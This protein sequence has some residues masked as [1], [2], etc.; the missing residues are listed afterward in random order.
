MEICELELAAPRSGEVEV[1]VEIA[2]AGV[3]GSDLHVV[4]GEWDVP[5]PV[6]LGPEG[7]RVVSA[8]G[9]DVTALA[10]GDHVILSWVPQ[11]GR[12]RQCR[13]ERPWQCER[14]ATVVA[15]GGV[16]SDHHMLPRQAGDRNVGVVT[17]WEYCR[18]VTTPDVRWRPDPAEK[19]RRHPFVTPQCAVRHEAGRGI[20]HR[21][22]H[23]P[24]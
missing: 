14:V 23:R 1:E 13:E 7:A 18:R 3:C 17:P 22:V 16:V 5:M 10:V 11:C 6:V 12:C 4:R 19:G 2:A 15:P 24:H 8:L 21:A 9:P 20:S